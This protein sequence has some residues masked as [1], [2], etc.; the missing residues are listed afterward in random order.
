MRVV[1]GKDADRCPR[2]PRRRSRQPRRR[3]VVALDVVENDRRGRCAVR[4]RSR[5]DLAGQRHRDRARDG[6]PG[7]PGRSPAARPAAQGIAPAGRRP[8]GAGPCAR[9][10][11]HDAADRGLF[12]EKT[13][14]LHPDLC[15]FT[16]EVFY[17]DRL[18]PE[19]HLVVQRVMRRMVRSSTAPDR[20]SLGVPTIGADSESPIEAEAVAALARAIVEGGALWVAAADG[21][22]RR[23]GWDDVLIVAPYNA[24][25]GAIKRRLPIEA[26]VG[27]VDKFQGQ[28]APISIYSMTTSSPEARAAGHGFP[29]QPPPT[30]RRHLPSS[31]RQRRRRVA[32]PL[33]RSRTDARADAPGERVLPLRGAGARDRMTRMCRWSALRRSR[34]PPIIDR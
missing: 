30:Q 9:R 19:A 32:G 26:R 12:L 18:E 4:R 11:R 7:A 5:P 23:V 6:Q 10:P 2:P 28:E 31:R 8:V 17:D 15:A 21:E 29:L 24:Q 14:R 34:Q 22:P 13:W 33:P 3:D 1:R 20:D 16:S 25:V 27:T